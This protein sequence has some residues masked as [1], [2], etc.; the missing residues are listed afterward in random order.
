[1]QIPAQHLGEVNV[2]KEKNYVLS[3][4]LAVA[5]AIAM[6]AVVVVDTLAPAVVLPVMNIPNMAGLCLIV[7][8]VEHYMAPNSRRCYFCVA[9][10]ALLTFGLLPFAAGFVAW[11]QA[12]KVAV[13]AVS[14]LAS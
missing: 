1:M 7:L 8:L 5:V 4:I 3:L 10:F 6:V 12:W 9:G 2:M 11:E 14:S 13:V